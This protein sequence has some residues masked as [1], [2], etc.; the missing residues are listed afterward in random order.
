LV[1]DDALVRETVARFLSGTGLDVVACGSCAEARALYAQRSFDAVITDFE[2]DDG[3]AI[4]LLRWIRGRDARAAV[5]VVTGRGTIDRAVESL[6]EGARDFLTKPIAFDRLRAMLDRVLRE[7]RATREPRGRIAFVARSPSMR[8]FIEELDAVA[9]STAPILLLGETGTGKS[10]I[11]REIHARSPR[12]K[13]PVI[14]VNG[15]GLRGD[16]LESELFG[17]ERG[18]FT[19]AVAPK[20]G[21]L[22][23]ADGGTLFLDE[24]G[25]IELE[26]QA[27]ILKVLEERRF[28][29]LGDVRE[30]TVDVRL[31]A[32][33]HRSLEQLVRAGS[34]REDLYYRISTLSLTVPPLRERR[35]DIAPL[36]EQL[37]DEIA[38]R[39]GLPPPTFA[40]SAMSALLAH[41]WPGNLRELRNVVERAVVLHPGRAVDAAQLR[42]DDRGG[43]AE[44]SASA[45]PITGTRPLEHAQRDAIEAALATARGH[46]GDAARLLGIPRSTLYAKL[47]AM[48]IDLARY[49]G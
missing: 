11:A 10:T 28:R 13:G 19:G 37:L 32:A 22:E 17:H 8:R 5:F 29:R 26:V 36:V 1:E 6:H 39:Q 23:E 25:D 7:R 12:A 35:D 47:H 38:A 15:A 44:R 34:F 49:R 14:D 2:L 33:T 3:D 42:F 4:S 43:R 9:R 24:I 18:A 16:F 45:D 48:A 21:L 41:D 31:V 30:R 20:S 27:K 40:A 46:V